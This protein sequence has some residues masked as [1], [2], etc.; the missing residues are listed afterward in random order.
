MEPIDTPTMSVDRMLSNVTGRPDHDWKTTMTRK[1]TAPTITAVRCLLRFTARSAQVE[2]A[3]AAVPPG[4]NGR[5]RLVELDGGHVLAVAVERAL[6]LREDPDVLAALHLHEREAPVELL[7]THI[8]GPEHP[9]AA[10][11]GPEVVDLRRLLEEAGAGQAVVAV[12]LHDVVDHVTEEKARRPRLRAEPVGLGTAAHVLQERVDG[13]VLLRFL[14]RDEEQ[15]RVLTVDVRTALAEELGV[16]ALECTAPDLDA[17]DTL[18]LRFFTKLHRAL[19]VGDALGVRGALVLHG[20]RH[21]R[22]IA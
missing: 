19:V 10:D 9:L 5:L 11:R 8:G 4:R 3:R 13:L 15:R 22:V 20:L 12:R 7:A 17:V 16:V 18:D 1:A 6:L 21:R 14:E 2:R